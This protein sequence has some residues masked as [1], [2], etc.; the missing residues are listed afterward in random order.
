MLYKLPRRG[1]KFSANQIA[2][3]RTSPKTAHRLADEL[4]TTASTICKIRNGWLYKG[5]KN[6]T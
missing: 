6:G 4:S 2:L 3:I 1:S 5:V